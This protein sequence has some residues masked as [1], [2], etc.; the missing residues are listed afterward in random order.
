M[1]CNKDARSG[2]WR[3]QTV[4]VDYFREEFAEA[5]PGADS[6]A[7]R[8]VQEILLK[9]LLIMFGGEAVDHALCIAGSLLQSGFPELLVFASAIEDVR[10]ERSQNGLSDLFTTLWV[11][12]LAGESVG[13]A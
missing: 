3:T 11:G 10:S 4:Q 6:L 13:E 5:V 12:A 9:R 1:R 8:E 2:A 7:T